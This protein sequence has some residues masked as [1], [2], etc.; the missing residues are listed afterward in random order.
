MQIA[1]VLYPGLTAL[2]TLGP[3]EI[4]KSLKGCDL[5]F[6]AAEVGP[7]TT[8]RGILLIGA[9]HTFAETPR[10]DLILVPG[11]EANTAIAAANSELISWLQKAHP[12]TI[13][14]TSVCSGAVILAAAGLLKGKPATTHWAAMSALKR[15][16]AVPQPEERIVQSGKIWTAAG[17]SA[18]LDL[19]L[20]LFGEIEG[21]S[22]AEQVQLMIEYDPQPPF[23]AGHISKA[24]DEVVESARQEMR[25]LS[26]NPGNF[27]AL[28]T[29]AWRQALSALR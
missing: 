26:K 23:D 3:Y 21:Q 24:S 11:S 2:D 8:D 20:A 29:L 5:R 17:V 6:V 9:T 13:Y 18:G 19:A 27:F 16:G 7:V 10:P 14:P 28:T 4:F 12:H 15:L 22:A 1:L 25:Y